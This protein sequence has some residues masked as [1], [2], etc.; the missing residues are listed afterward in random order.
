LQNWYYPFTIVRQ[1]KNG[2]GL[3]SAAAKRLEMKDERNATPVRGVVPLDRMPG[4]DEEDQKLLAAMAA[5]AQSYVESF[6]WCKDVKNV[7]FG[8]G[9]GGI[10]AVFLFHVEPSQLGVDEWLWIIVGDVPPA[11]L[12]LDSA[13]TPSQA[14]E[15]YLEE[16]SKWVQLAK[17]GR[18]SDEVIPVNVPATLEN[19]TNLE[20]RLTTLRNLIL[21]NFRISEEAA[22]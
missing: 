19:A 20:T 3:T 10:I 14:L 12:V 15:R 8:D 5:Y 1:G 22:E 7:Y 9:Y 17:L 16:M 11:Y 4:D 18:T 21:P 2:S 13:K 6:K